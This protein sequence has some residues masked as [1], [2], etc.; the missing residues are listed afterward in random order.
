M[1]SRVF[2]APDWSQTLLCSCATVEWAL[3]DLHCV[4]Y[5]GVT[6]RSIMLGSSVSYDVLRFVALQCNL[7]L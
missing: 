4:D 3:N 2:S 6:L 7:C 1:C 5:H